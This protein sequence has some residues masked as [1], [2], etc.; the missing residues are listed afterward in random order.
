[1]YYTVQQGAAT[2]GKL[3]VLILIYQRCSPVDK[4]IQKVYLF[5]REAA[6]E[7]FDEVSTD[8]FV[9]IRSFICSYLLRGIGN[10]SGHAYSGFHAD[11]SSPRVEPSLPCLAPTNL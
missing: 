11:G 6:E 4:A 2:L 7:S 9:G 3:Q 10:A 1:M 5:I 8:P